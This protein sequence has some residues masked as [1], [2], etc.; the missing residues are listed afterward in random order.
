LREKINQF[1]GNQGSPKALLGG[2]GSADF[3]IKTIRYS[4]IITE[5][6]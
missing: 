3:D 4:T 2:I 5:Q 6:Q 1:L